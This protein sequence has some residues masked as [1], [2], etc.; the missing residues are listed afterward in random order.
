MNDGEIY[1]VQSTPTIFING[2]MLAELSP[3]GLKD[4]IDKALA[5]SSQ[6]PNK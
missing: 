3:E 2:V 1:G 4:A 5:A 6:K